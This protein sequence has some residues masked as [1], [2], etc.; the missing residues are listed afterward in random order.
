MMAFTA[1]L[2]SRGE[3]LPVNDGVGSR[4][5]CPISGGLGRAGQ[6]SLFDLPEYF[7]Q[8]SGS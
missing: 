2:S 8:F 5:M 1:Q 4:I 6:H 3:N 7:I